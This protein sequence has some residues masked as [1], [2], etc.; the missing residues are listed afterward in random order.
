MPN[1]IC[2]EINTAFEGLVEETYGTDFL[3]E[4]RAMSRDK[5]MFWAD[6]IFEE[7]K[8][9]IRQD[10]LT[11]AAMSRWDDYFGKQVD[12]ADNVTYTNATE[13]SLNDTISGIGGRTPGIVS[14]EATQR[15]ILKDFQGTILQGLEKFRA[16]GFGLIRSMKGQKNVI[17]EL[18]KPG[19]TGDKDAAD[20]AKVI[21]KGLESLR[22]QFNNAG[23]S[24]DELEDYFLPQFNDPRRIKKFGKD[25]YVEFVKKRVDVNRLFY[26]V[27]PGK[28]I[29]DKNT[30]RLLG[31]VW[32]NISSGGVLHKEIAP[33]PRIRRMIGSHHQEHR[34]LHFNNAEDWIAYAE[35]FGA[36]DYVQSIHSHAEMMSKEI[37]AMDLFGPNADEMMRFNRRRV[38]QAVAQDP[39]FKGTP[40]EAGQRAEASYDIV[41][42]KVHTQN[43][44]FANI[45][46]GARNTTVGL[47]IGKAIIS[48]ISDNM[49][50]AQT[51]YLRGMPVMD[52][53]MYIAK[54]L[55]N[56][57]EHRLLAGHLNLGAEYAIEGGRSAYR[58]AE[59]IGTGG[60][61]KFAEFMVKASGL[62]FWTNVARDSYG[63]N[64]LHHLGTLRDR[65]YKNLHPRIRETFSISGITSK[66]W[67]NMRSAPVFEHGGTVYMQ[68]RNFNDRNQAIK[69]V[70]SVIEGQHLAVP[71]LNAKVISFTRGTAPAGSTGGEAVR[72]MMTFKSF[73]TTVIISHWAQ[74]LGRKGAWNK[75]GY[76]ASLITGTT[77]LGAVALQTKQLVMGKTLLDM[78]SPSFWAAALLQGG[79]V[80]I[81]GDFLFQ[82]HSRVTSI[83]EFLGGPLLSDATVIVGLAFGS[84]SDFAHARDSIGKKM[85]KRAARSLDHI[86]PKLWQTNLL[87][88]RYV[89]DDIQ[90]MLNP[91]WASEQRTMQ[92]KMADTRGNRFYWAPGD[93][94]PGG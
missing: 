74:G 66:D 50:T 28:V 18:F 91:D 67:D 71:E 80:G 54:G 26:H 3:E 30:T 41:M 32:E 2:P 1:K 40:S 38:Q 78:R 36:F 64:V 22:K 27:E 90:Q 52:N 4:F 60:T 48:A 17:R 6:K 73:A 61:S 37:A 44:K 57:K 83:G 49:F 47:K 21:T 19:S 12:D 16:R 15:A 34:L 79:G 58:V 20:I 55:V 39:K 68:P 9:R 43:T 77:V 88:K 56:N 89:T 87:L 86:M 11:A 82:D 53:F 76:L 7:V 69:L 10:K 72:S 93:K 59:V 35:E 51:A 8:S 5:K 70:G 45:M 24:I 14:L 13:G 46:Q 63:L 31:R 42:G 92:R 84:P 62:N 81:L 75:L 33:D 25:K 29:S 65:A 23:G 85:S 94:L